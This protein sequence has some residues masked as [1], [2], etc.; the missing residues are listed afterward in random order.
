MTTTINFPDIQLNST[1]PCHVFNQASDLAWQYRWEPLPATPDTLLSLYDELPADVRMLAMFTCLRRAHY[2]F[3]FTALPELVAAIPDPAIRDD[4]HIRVLLQCGEA[5]VH[6]DSTVWEEL[7]RVAAAA[8]TDCKIPHLALTTLYA[9]EH[10]NLIALNKGAL[11]A[12]RQFKITG[13]PVYG[14]RVVS[15]RRR[16]GNVREA[17]QALDQVNNHMFTHTDTSPELA[18]HLSERL[19]GERFLLQQQIDNNN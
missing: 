18:D 7:L 8:G 5:Y 6:N 11:L 14:Y 16:L 19:I 2:T 9:S 1:G 3:A 4:A 15:L 17:W 13:D 10:A 12:E